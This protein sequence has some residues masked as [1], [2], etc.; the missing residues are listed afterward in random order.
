M[1]GGEVEVV[2]SFVACAI[3]IPIVVIGWIR[4]PWGHGVDTQPARDD[5]RKARRASAPFRP[6]VE[7][8]P[9]APPVRERV[10]D[11]INGGRG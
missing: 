10:V 11:V 8:S 9:S 3:A 1:N 7:A 5:E 4:D 2:V 6:H